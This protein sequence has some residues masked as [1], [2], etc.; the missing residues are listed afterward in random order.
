MP[1]DGF[2]H[3]FQVVYPADPEIWKTYVNLPGEWEAFAR[4]GKTLARAHYLTPEVRPCYAIF[5]EKMV[6]WIV[7]VKHYG[8]VKTSRL[9]KSPE[10]L[11]EQLTRDRR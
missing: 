8:H 7:L 2:V 4:Q 10:P 3:R 1:E 5:L 9:G 6:H 11:Q